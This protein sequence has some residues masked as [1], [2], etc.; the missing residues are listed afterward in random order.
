M[1]PSAETSSNVRPLL[2]FFAMLLGTAIAFFGLGFLRVPDAWAKPLTIV[3]TVVFIAT[4][5]LAIFKASSAKWTPKLA[6]AFLGFG[7]ILQFGLLAL[8]RG[9]LVGKGWV[10]GLA[11]AFS[12]FGLIVWCIGLGALITTMLKDRN[13]LLPVS[14]FL[15]LFDMYAVFTPGG[16]V[17][18]LLKSAPD[19]LPSMAYQAP[20]VTSVQAVAGPV[21]SAVHPYAFIGP[22]DFLFMGM[23]FVAVFRFGLRTRQ[24]FQWMLVA[25]AAWI[26]LAPFLGELPLLVPIGLSVLLVNLPEFKL[27]KEEWAS[28]GVIAAIGI[29]LVVWGATR[30]KPAVHI[31]RES[32]TAPSPSA[33]GSA[34]PRSAGSPEPDAQGQSPSASP[35]A[36]GS[37][38]GPR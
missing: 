25:L 23:F 10:D 35:P 24:T 33:G 32:P 18:V 14:I 16:P 22:A 38:P 8:H 19:L 7:L 34:A 31:V 13:L 20:S 17:Q 26:C 1:Q 37:T 28:T 29:A 12:Q 4:P 36:P 27:N 15:A 21:G 6:M 30:P 5:V 3:V 2:I 11:V 9:P